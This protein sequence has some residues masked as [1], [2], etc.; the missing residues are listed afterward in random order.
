MENSPNQEKYRWASTDPEF[1]ECFVNY[2]FVIAADAFPSDIITQLYDLISSMYTGYKKRFIEAHQDDPIP[3]VGITKKVIEEFERDPLYSEWIR[4]PTLLEALEKILGPDISKTCMTGFFPVD[5]DDQ[6]SAIV[7]DLHQ[8][9]WTGGGP[10]DIN[11][12][13]PLHAT[14]LEDSLLV[15][16]GSHM[17]GLLPNRNRKVVLE[18]DIQIPEAIPLLMQKGDIVFFHS[19]LLHG[20]AGVGTQMRYAIQNAY[21][22]TFAPMTVNQKGL[23]F[24]NLKQGP[25]TRIRKILGND[26]LTPL[27]TYGGKLSNNEEYY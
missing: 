23:G 25:M 12:W 27:R 1:I 11:S 19:L 3:Y 17:F 16:P 8:E 9:L 4:T 10:D 26:F 18:D 21:R 20:G 15:V 5:P 13:T 24:V 7:K 2:G 6:S 14:R 22:D